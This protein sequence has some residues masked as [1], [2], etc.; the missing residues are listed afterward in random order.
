MQVL[1]CMPV[2]SDGFVSWTLEKIYYVLWGGR[3]KLLVKWPGPCFQGGLG[4]QSEG[5]HVLGYILLH[6]MV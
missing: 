5:L 4:T 2:K 1:P 3:A 6:P